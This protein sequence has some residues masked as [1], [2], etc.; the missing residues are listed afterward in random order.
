[1]YKDYSFEYNGETITVDL[2]ALK[3]KEFDSSSLKNKNEFSFTLPHSSNEI[4]FSK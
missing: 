3:E 1:M 4:T 2:S